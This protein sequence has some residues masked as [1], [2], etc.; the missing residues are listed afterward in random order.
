MN[1][2]RKALSAIGGI[3]LAALLIAALAPKAA[4]GVAAALVEVTN[5]SVNPVPTYDSSTRFQAEICVFSGPVATAENFCG[6]N[7]SSSFV[8]PANT[9]GGAAVKRLVVDNMGGFCS[10]FNNPTLLLEAVGLTSPFVPDSAPNGDSSAAHYLP[11]VGQTHGYVND[12]SIGPPLAGVPE[13][14]YSFGQ[15][16]HFSFNPGSTVGAFY[17]YSYT[18]VGAIDVGCSVKI[19]GFLATQ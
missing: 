6:S 8:V 2:T 14:D 18:G 3:F 7:T 12:P 10:S 19:E 11:L 17:F 5:T 16:T 9:S 15:N 13:T 1:I 4:R